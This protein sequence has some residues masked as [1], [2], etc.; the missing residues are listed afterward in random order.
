MTDAA[1]GSD[2]TGN[3]G[4][5]STTVAPPGSTSSEVA[6]APAPAPVAHEF[7]WLGDADETRVGYVQNKGWKE[8]G[9]VLDSYIA[10]EKTFG[11][12]KAGRTVIL[13][14]E[15]A[16]A[17][18]L[19]AFYAKLG[20]PAE[21]KDYKVTVP[22]GHDPKFADGFKA[23][24]HELG[25]TAKQVEG[26]AA[27]NNE[28]VAGMQSAQA[29][30]SVES[31]NRDVQTLKTE[32]GAAHD[33]NVVVAR[34]AAQALGLS[35]DFIDKVSGAVGHKATME[36]LHKIGSKTGESEFVATSSTSYGGALTPGQAKA[37]IAA[38]KQDKAFMAK[39][40][41]GDA[42]AKAKWTKL[43]NYAFPE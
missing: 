20:R 4:T 17:A 21:P 37:E 7:K 39:V 14:G 2:T 11:A 33:Q 10:L 42:E 34:S 6:G 19:D 1:T 43:H 24:A 29:N 32:W 22:E 23:K 35:A 36:L 38:H 26:L 25:L 28:Q 15:K 13:P 30:Q 3:P 16:E 40:F 5:T 9:Q 12:D 8:P 41:S 31:F 18:E 27:W